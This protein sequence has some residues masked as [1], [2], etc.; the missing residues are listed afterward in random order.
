MRASD[1]DWLAQLADAYDVG[2][3][4]SAVGAAIYRR[5]RAPASWTLSRETLRDAPPEWQAI[6][7]VLGQVATRPADFGRIRRG[8]RP[9]G[10]S[11]NA[12]ASMVAVY[13]LETPADEF[14]DE[15]IAEIASA[16]TGPA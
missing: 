2:R 4:L 11:W 15:V 14:I 9:T 13:P 10:P 8:K 6:M 7:Q 5:L 1:P 16:L 12:L 3:D